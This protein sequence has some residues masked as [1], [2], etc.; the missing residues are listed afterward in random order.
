MQIFHCCCLFRYVQIFLG[1]LIALVKL[2]SWSGNFIGRIV[3]SVFSKGYSLRSFKFLLNLFLI[4]TRLWN[5]VSVFVFQIFYVF[6][7]LVFS[8]K[9]CFDVTSGRFFHLHGRFDP[10]W[11]T[12]CDLWFVNAML[13]T[14]KTSGSSFIS[15][16][17]NMWYMANWTSFYITFTISRII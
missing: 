13:S 12:I 3:L 17:S 8:V 16:S 9:S 1:D 7:L 4:R 5:P 11:I 10:V 15:M 2:F 14:T 6:F